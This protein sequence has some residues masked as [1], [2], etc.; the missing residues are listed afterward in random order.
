MPAD[1]PLYRQLLRRQDALT[2]YAFGLLRDW[3]LAEDAVQEVL[4]SVHQKD[5]ALQL[6]G[7]IQAWAHVVVKNKAIDL[8]RKRGHERPLPDEDLIALVD[9][10]F[11]LHIDP[12]YLAR[13]ER[14]KSAMRGC[15][16]KLS[17]QALALLLRFYV[18]GASYRE[19]ATE[20]HRSADALRVTVLR[21]RKK[22]ADCITKELRGAE[23]P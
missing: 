14:R 4:L 23:T 3:S 18:E 9:Q 11:A 7:D 13:M 22:L 17:D 10:Q 12:E 21:I 1:D 15:L 2:A 5:G 6:E 19:L 20:V 8:L 16:P